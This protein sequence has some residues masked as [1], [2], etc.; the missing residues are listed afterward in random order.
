ER[1]T[2]V[3]IQQMIQQNPAKLA[4]QVMG[5]PDESIKW[6]TLEEVTS[7]W[8]EQDLEATVSWIETLPEGRAKD[9]GIVGMVSELRGNDPELAMHWAKTLGDNTLRQEQ[10]R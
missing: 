8:A 5:L 2:K 10:S 7:A 4:S 9:W 3:A 1:V 6:T